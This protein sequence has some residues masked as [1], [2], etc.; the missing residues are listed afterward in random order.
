MASLL[1]VLERLALIIFYRQ[2]RF[3]IRFKSGLPEWDCG[4]RATRRQTRWLFMA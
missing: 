2:L 1:H 4:S 3:R